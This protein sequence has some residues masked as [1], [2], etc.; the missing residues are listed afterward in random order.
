MASPAWSCLADEV[1]MGLGELVGQ[2]IARAV[3]AVGAEERYLVGADDLIPELLELQG[4]RLV[5]HVQD[6]DHLAEDAHGA[7]L[8]ST[9][10]LGPL[11]EG[12]GSEI[13]PSRVRA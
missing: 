11:D 7:G 4:G 8:R 12:G 9:A 13:E 2:L 10:R 5:L 3:Q 6:A 1:R